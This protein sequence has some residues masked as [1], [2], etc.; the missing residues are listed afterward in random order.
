[1]AASIGERKIAMLLDEGDIYYET[2]Y[3]FPDLKSV[4]GVHL[5][6]DFAVFE[7]P[8]DPRPKFLV[9]YQGEQ[10]YKKKFQTTE[11]FARQLA[12]DKRKRA[13]C[14]AKGLTLVAIPFTEYHSMT[15]DS[16]LEQG[17]YFD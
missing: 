2:E 6:F 16:I 10:H 13:Y 9:E 3:L 5:R 8:G 14:S 11:S 17:K 1:M 7:A 15:L 4:R 12:N